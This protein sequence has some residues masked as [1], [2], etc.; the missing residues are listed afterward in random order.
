MHVDGSVLLAAYIPKK[1]SRS[2]HKTFVLCVCDFVNWLLIIDNLAAVMFRA[3]PDSPVKMLL[4]PCHQL[5]FVGL[6]VSKLTESHQPNGACFWHR[7]KTLVVCWRSFC[8][9]PPPPSFPTQRNRCW[10]GDAGGVLPF[11]SP[12]L[13]G[14]S[15]GIPSAPLSVSCR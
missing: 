6:W 1:C 2:I 13:S 10:R 8:T 3:F 7:H 9:P 15:A 12:V 14:W 11:C 4:L 5:H